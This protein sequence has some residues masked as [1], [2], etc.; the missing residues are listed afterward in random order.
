MNDTMIGIMRVAGLMVV[1]ALTVGCGG[2]PD[3]LEVARSGLDED[4]DLWADVPEASVDRERVH[5]GTGC[6]YVF[7]TDRVKVPVMDVS[8]ISAES[9]SLAVTLWA[10][11]EILQN[12][13][14]LEVLIDSEG[15]D[16]RLART[17]LT[18]VRR[19][20]PWSP[21]TATFAL[22]EGELPNRI[23]VALIIPDPGKLWID[24]VAVWD[25]AS[26]PDME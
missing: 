20:T 25:G 23:R 5:E 6:L 8:G 4:S 18:D 17:T 16:P 2:A 11:T 26:T 15:R 3:A 24:D 14:I 12:Q 21:A 9:D 7:A 22:L 13:A 10:R 19:T 1:A